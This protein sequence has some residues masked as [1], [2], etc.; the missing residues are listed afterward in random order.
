MLAIA[1]WTGQIPRRPPLPDGVSVSQ[2]IALGSRR[3]RS[4]VYW[5]IAKSEEEVSLVRL[6]KQYT[7]RVT[8][9]GQLV[10]VNRMDRFIGFFSWDVQQRFTW[11]KIALIVFAVTY[12][13][14]AIAAMA[15]ASIKG[16]FT[17]R[18]FT[19]SFVTLTGA[20]CIVMWIS[21]AV[22]RRDLTTTVAFLQQRQSAIHKHNAPRKALLDRVTRYLWLFYLQNIAQVFFWI[23]LLRDCSPL[24]VFELSLLDSANVLLYPIAMTLMSLMFIHTIMIVSTLLSGLTLEFYWLGQ[25]FEQVFAECSSISVT[26]HQRYWDALEQ[27]IGMCVMEHQRLLGQISKLRNNLKLY[28]LLNLVADFSLI[29]FAGCQMVI[30]SEGDQHLY[31]ILAA[32]TACLN[33]LNFGGLCDLLKIQVHAI[34]FHLYSS[35]WTDYLRPVSGPLYQRCRRIRSSIL[36]VMTRAEH[37]L[38]ISCGSVYD[39]SLA[40]CWAVLQFSYSL[41]PPPQIELVVDKPH[42]MGVLRRP[43]VRI[44][45]AT[46][47]E[48][49]ARRKNR[50]TIEHNTTKVKGEAAVAILKKNA[51]DNTDPKGSLACALPWGHGWALTW[52]QCEDSI[53][54]HALPTTHCTN[55]IEAPCA[56]GIYHTD[57]GPFDLHGIEDVGGE[58]FDYAMDCGDF[59]F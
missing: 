48:V 24:A 12:E 6:A 40:T 38:R 20:M 23:N 28:L 7:Q 27:R 16:V 39:M 54:L 14:T 1:H 45:P 9:A 26:W 47:S 11:L 59:I 34:K 5:M 17:E 8:D 50:H 42:L 18:S 31:S 55:M 58:D 3:K 10:I 36:I 19:M 33:M 52:S 53:T 29:T 57:I 49:S 35:Q 41:P 4:K 13:T 56:S 51:Q 25:E 32:L 46:S 37:E 2:L 15:L 43:V 30:S 22:F 44:R 21:L